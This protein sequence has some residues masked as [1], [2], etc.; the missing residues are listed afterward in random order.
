MFIAKNFVMAF[1]LEILIF[2]S[3][4]RFQL[5]HLAA[6]SHKT[7]VNSSLVNRYC[8]SSINVQMLRL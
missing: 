1:P 2:R 3:S 4:T 6:Y 7:E 8:K 5:A